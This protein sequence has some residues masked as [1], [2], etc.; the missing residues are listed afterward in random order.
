MYIIFIR[1]KF[2]LQRWSIACYEENLKL[3]TIFDITIRVQC[4]FRTKLINRTNQKKS[5]IT[6]LTAKCFSQLFWFHSQFQFLSIDWFLQVL[7]LKRRQQLLSLVD[8]S[9]QITIATVTE[10]N[11]NR[12]KVEW[13]L[14]CKRNPQLSVINM[15]TQVVGW[16]IIF[17]YWLL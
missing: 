13:G 1:R 5:R 2:K 6:D 7:P 3:Q 8:M 10:S 12:E 16:L 17:Q 9:A 14:S 15:A 4:S 11:L